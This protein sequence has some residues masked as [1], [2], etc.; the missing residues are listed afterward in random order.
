MGEVQLRQRMS[1][2]VLVTGGAGYIGSLLAGVLLN[3]GYQVVVID[4][5]LYGGE[6]LLGYWHHPG[7]H[8]VNGD[9]CN[10]GLFHVAGSSLK[11]GH[12]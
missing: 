3:R 11:I 1:R 7:F 4:D 6:S 2:R 10:S 5:L 12:L 8:F 9:V